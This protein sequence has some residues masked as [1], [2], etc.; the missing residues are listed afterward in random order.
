MG[1]ASFAVSD[2]VW[3]QHV[4]GFNSGE[5]ATHGA[6]HTSLVQFSVRSCKVEGSLEDSMKS[7]F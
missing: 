7:H 3:P 5:S 2:A 1:S 4:G 6:V